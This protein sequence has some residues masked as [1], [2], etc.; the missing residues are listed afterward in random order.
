MASMFSKPKQ[1]ALP[2][3]PPPDRSAERA[4][5]QETA[6][7][8]ALAESKGRGRSSTVRAG[9]AIALKKRQDKAKGLGAS[10]ALGLETG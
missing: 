6:R 9:R 5:Q 8:N 7:K 3:V 10:N 2:P 1:Q 4:A